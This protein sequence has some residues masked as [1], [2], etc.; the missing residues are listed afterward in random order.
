MSYIYRVEIAIS[1]AAHSPFTNSDYLTPTSNLTGHVPN[2]HTS[3]LHP[4][5]TS[6]KPVIQFF[7][8]LGINHRW[9]GGA[10]AYVSG[11]GAWSN[12]EQI[13]L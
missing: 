12:I 6:D 5:M 8:V 9:S 7:T 11:A 13:K 1:M 3:M 4:G 2:H 10:P